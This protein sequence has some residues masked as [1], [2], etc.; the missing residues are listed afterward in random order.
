MADDTLVVRC[1]DGAKKKHMR[2]RG[3]VKIDAAKNAPARSCP[4]GGDGCI[5]D[6]I[7]QP[8]LFDVLEGGT[9]PDSGVPFAVALLGLGSVKGLGHK[10]LRALVRHFMEDLGRALTGPRDSILQVFVEGRVAGAEK[11]ADV[12][13]ADH[14]KLAEEGR[15][16]LERLSGSGVYVLSPSKVP[17][18]LRF[19]PDPPYWLFVEGN[20]AALEQRPMVAVVGTREPSEKGLRA[21]SVVTKILAPYPVTLVSGLAEGIDAEAHRTSLA[22]GIRNVAFLGHGIDT[23]FPT[24]TADLR[25]EI[26]RAKGAIVTEYLPGEKYQKR[27]FVQRNRLQAG[28]SDLVIPVEAQQTGGTSHTV[29]FAQRYSRTVVALRWPGCNDFAAE[30]GTEGSAVLEIMTQDGCRKLDG[31]VRGLVERAGKDAY[32]LAGAERQLLREMRSRDVRPQDIRRL[33][34]T[35]ED[36]HKEPSNGGNGANGGGA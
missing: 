22:M 20:P 28:L 24:A 1:A 8:D 35:L 19:I 16:Q 15:I 27:Y 13:A 9:A 36:A 18:W 17:E 34:R 14:K 25:Q 5:M 12:I 30:L 29:R 21:A 23:V 33:I 3:R 6:A 4:E 11:F 32:P 26:V 2:R 10:G 31:I 7:K